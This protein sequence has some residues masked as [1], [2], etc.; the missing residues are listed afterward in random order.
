MQQENRTA[1]ILLHPTSLPGGFG[2]GEFGTDA[3]RFIDGLAATGCK[4][5][6]IL[7]LSPT[8]Y[9]SSPYSSYSTFAGN[10][11]LISIE[12]LLTDGWLQEKDIPLLPENSN[13][14][15]NFD[16]LYAWKLPILKNSYQQFIAKASKEEKKWFDDYRKFNAKWLD[17]YALFMAIK[18]QQPN[19]SWNEWDKALVARDDKAIKNAKE[20]LSTEIEFQ[21]F[22][23]FIFD[24]QWDGI[25]NHCR[26][27][28]IE[29]IGDVPIFVAF[30]SSDVWANQELFYLQADGKPSVIAGVPPD[31]F[32]ETG[33][34]WGNPLYNWDV[35]Q[36]DNYQW[37][38]ER[39]EYTFKRIDILRIDH[40]RGLEAYWE[41][42]A[43][44]KTAVNGKWVKAPG[45][46]LLRA[47]KEKF[48]N[49][50][51]I[52]E[53][54]GVITPEVDA[55]REKYNLPG[56]RVLQFAFGAEDPK[57]AT[58]ACH[59][60]TKNLVIYTGTHDNDTTMGWFYGKDNKYDI[61]PEETRQLERQNCLDYMGLGEDIEINWKL[62]SLAMQSVASTAI[63]PFQDILGL[64]C[65]ARFNRPGIA[66]DMNWSWRMTSEQLDAFCSKDIANRLNHLIYLYGRK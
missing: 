50:K 63:I 40:F 14:T 30:D 11:L 17:D 22:M 29:I 54:L 2:I 28:G 27:V 38:L 64:G 6:Q 34:L 37:W 25:R 9:G 62:I 60:H 19:K 26:E 56:M 10:P 46:D 41:V 61:R 18:G 42:D 57:T 32:C 8:G 39:L 47:V 20:K 52:A 16:S 48:G 58:H 15:V 33:Q 55:L 45:D 5:W 12:A 49:L 24:R 59:N 23:Q 43:K 53:D 3:H 4:L 21:S 1:G 31:Y 36:K 44:E 65:E 66:G 7:P 13:T 35:H 51:I